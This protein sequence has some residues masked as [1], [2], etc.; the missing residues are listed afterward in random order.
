MVRIETATADDA[1]EAAV[2]LA[3][4]FADDPVIARFVPPTASRR[5]QRL[6]GMFRG[7]VRAAGPGNVD[8]ARD[9][10]RGEVILGVAVWRAPEGGAG[11]VG[12]LAALGSALRALGPRGVLMLGQYN[13]ALRPH[14]PKEPHW[15]LEDIGT[16][17]EARGL[18]VGKALLTHRLAIV[19][20]SQRPAVLE[21]TTPASRRL[22]ERYGFAAAAEPTTGL[23]SGA[24]V[25]VRPA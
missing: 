16:R 14:V 9:D 6:R 15:H 20:R 7:A 23:L 17:A 13:R 18:G 19:D 2:V 12:A 24:A 5:E 8:I 21:A 1:E 3:E 11:V 25:M 22:Y 4:A 10:T